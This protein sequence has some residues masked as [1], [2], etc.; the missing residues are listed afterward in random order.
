M[1]EHISCR[2]G[3]S[4]IAYDDIRVYKIRNTSTLVDVGINGDLRF[5]N[6]DSL[7]AAGNIRT[8]LLDTCN[9]FSNPI[10]KEINIDTTKP[11]AIA[12]INDGVGADEDETLSTTTLLGNWLV[13]TDI[14]SNIAYYEYAIGTQSG[15]SNVVSWTNIGLSNSFIA[16][17]LS[18]LQDTTYYVTVRARNGAGLFSI[19]AISDGIKRT[20]VLPVELI[21]F[22]GKM[23]DNTIALNWTTLSEQNTKEF[24]I[25][26]S[27][28][29]MDFYTIGTENA[30]GYSNQKIDYN[31]IDNEIDVS[32]QK[33]YYRLKIVDFDGTFSFSPIVVI[34]INTFK[35]NEIKIYPNPFKEVITI[36]FNF[37]EYK[38]SK[39]VLFDNNG[40]IA[41]TKT[42]TIPSNKT[43]IE[44]N[45]LIH[46]PKGVYYLNIFDNETSLI[47]RTEKIIKQ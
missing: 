1:A 36:E 12:I 15:D 17:S 5:E 45:E 16:S 27:T 39:L 8:L 29:G 43:T 18:L 34:S 44:L 33:Y 38:N 47:L 35:T 25:E 9:R 2:T 11:N 22:N 31:F 21:S 7:T 19:V 6:P 40:K 14:N 30:T 28:N 10:E 26:R 20:S 23:L 32:I 13:S 42:I 37:S 46:L 41:F 3:N 24:I 4:K